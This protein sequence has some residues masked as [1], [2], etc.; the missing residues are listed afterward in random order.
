MLDR[1]PIQIKVK[2]ER[3]CMIAFV[4]LLLGFCL[5]LDILRDA[6][7]QFKSARSSIQNGEGFL[8][9]PAQKQHVPRLL[10]TLSEGS[11]PPQTN[12]HVTYHP[13]YHPADQSEYEPSESHGLEGKDERDFSAVEHEMAMSETLPAVVLEVSDV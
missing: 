13:G 8:S 12:L 4:F 1:D 3:S 9:I 10:E 5:M 6:D 2:S 7:S 11:R